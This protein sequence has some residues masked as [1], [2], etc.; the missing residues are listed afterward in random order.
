MSL[1]DAAGSMANDSV[2]AM[3]S[4][5]ASRRSNSLVFSECSRFVEHELR[6]QRVRGKPLTTTL[7]GQEGLL[8]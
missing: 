3:P 6:S 4:F 5:G 8:A 1:T 2:S 7:D